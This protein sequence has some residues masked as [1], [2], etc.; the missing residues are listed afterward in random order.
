[1]ISTKTEFFFFKNAAWN[2]LHCGS[3]SLNNFSEGHS[4]FDALRRDTRTVE[5]PRGILQES[6]LEVSI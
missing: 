3:P 2:M 6:P 5:T 1:M 4:Q